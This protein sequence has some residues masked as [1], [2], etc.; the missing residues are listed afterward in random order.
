[1]ARGCKARLIF[2]THDEN[3]TVRLAA[4]DFGASEACTNRAQFRR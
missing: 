2:V 3:D 1:M 4:I